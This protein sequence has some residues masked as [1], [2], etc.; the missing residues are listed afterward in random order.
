ME[1]SQIN[2]AFGYLSILLGHLCLSDLVKDRFGSS[3][4]ESNNLKLLV[5]YMRE[6]IAY[7]QA[8]EEAI[9]AHNGEP[10]SSNF[11]SRLQGLVDELEDRV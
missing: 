5:G 1:K 6:F 11:A 9:A 2:V 4:T 10:A 7:N 3:H 8:A